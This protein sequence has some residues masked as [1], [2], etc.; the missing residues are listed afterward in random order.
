MFSILLENTATR[1]R[2][3]TC[4]FWLPKCKFSLLVTIFLKRILYW[5]GI[6]LEYIVNMLGAEVCQASKIFCLWHKNYK[7]LCDGRMTTQCLTQCL[8]PQMSFLCL[9]LTSKQ[10]QLS[11]D[12]IS[13]ISLDRKR[14][15]HCFKQLTAINGKKLHRKKNSE[16]YIR[17]FTRPKWESVTSRGDWSE[18]CTPKQ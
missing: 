11:L 16:I 13:V 3:T 18:N 2:K 17:T 14:I 12:W 5:F 7:K 10:A 15:C 8:S 9:F 4:Q 6:F 1:K